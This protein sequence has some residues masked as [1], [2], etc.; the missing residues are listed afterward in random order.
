MESELQARAEAEFGFT[1]RSVRAPKGELDAVQVI[2]DSSPDEWFVASE[3]EKLIAPIHG[4]ASETCV[5]CGIVRWMPVGMDILPPPPVDVLASE[6]PV[7]ASPE[8]FGAGYQSFRQILWRRDVAE[9]LLTVG[10]R[11]FR[12]QELRAR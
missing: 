3:L 9:F 12:I 4:E 10:P 6:P 8:W 2:I 7:V 5:V 11:D 1:F